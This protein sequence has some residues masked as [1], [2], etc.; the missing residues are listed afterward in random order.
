[1]QYGLTEHRYFSWTTWSSLIPKLCQDWLNKLRCRRRYHHP[2]GLG[3]RIF[4]VKVPSPPGFAEPPICSGKTLSKVIMCGPNTGRSTLV[5]SV[6]VL[7][8]AWF[9]KSHAGQPLLIGPNV[10]RSTLP[11][12]TE[13]ISAG[14]SGPYVISPNPT[15][16]ANSLRVSRF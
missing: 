9:S 1:L 7:A 8:S 14:A 2:L 6:V 15:S 10:G 5:G 16:A 11:G 12:R 4:S 13:P 3:T